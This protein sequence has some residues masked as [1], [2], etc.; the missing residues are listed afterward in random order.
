MS[1]P[2]LPDPLASGYSVQPVD[3][4]ARTPM[5]VGLPRVR[6]RSDASYYHVTAQWLLTDAQMTAFDTWW[7]GDGRGGAVWFN[8]PIKI[9]GAKSTRSSRFMAP[10]KVT[11]KQPGVW[12]MSGKLEVRG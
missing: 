11:L 2:P 9:R 10:P 1:S 4:T 3:Q 12:R 7:R 5:D 6:L 8:M